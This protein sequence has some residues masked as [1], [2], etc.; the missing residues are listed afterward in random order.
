MHPLT[1]EDIQA[2]AQ[3][4]NKLQQ[5]T[6][7]A[8]AV[9]SLDQQQ[10]TP[11]ARAQTGANCGKKSPNQN[12]TTKNASGWQAIAKLL[13]IIGLFAFWACVFVVLLVKV[14]AYI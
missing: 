6:K 2:I 3:E 10:P 4:L 7:T 14:L 9:R 5:D 1:T 8:Q 13:S 11:S 12:A